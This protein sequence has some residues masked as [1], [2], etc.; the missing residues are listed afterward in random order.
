[1]RFSRRDF[2]RTT[3]AAG[4]GAAVF[5]APAGAWAAPRATIRVG[6]IGCGGRGSGAAN[7][8]VKG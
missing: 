3:A 2:I 5:G 1:M 8:A 7:D 4:A 6:L